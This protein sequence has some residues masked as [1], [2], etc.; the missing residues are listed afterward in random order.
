MTVK[1]FPT[2]LPV[3]IATYEKSLEFL[4]PVLSEVLLY[5]VILCLLDIGGWHFMFTFNSVGPDSGTS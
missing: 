1:P 4:G 5:T 2:H 3:T